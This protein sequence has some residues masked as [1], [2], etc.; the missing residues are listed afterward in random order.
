MDFL[1]KIKSNPYHVLSPLLMSGLLNGLPDEQF[2]K[3]MYRAQMG[4]K[5]DLDDPKTLNEK[6]QWLKL[7]DRNPDYPIMV[8][9]YD[10]KKYVAEKIGEEYIIPTLGVWERFEDIDFEALPDSFVLNCTHDSGGLVVVKDKKKLDL[11]A[12][13]KKIN[14]SL[15]N[16]YYYL[17]REWPYK[18]IKPRIIAE[19]YMEDETGELVDYKF[20][21]FNGKVDCV[22]GCFD[23][24]SGD[25]KFYFFDRG[26][27]LKRYNK[28][29]KEAP[30]G[31]TKPKPRN[32]DRMFD[33]AE[34]L[35][36]IVGAP[37][38]R[39]DLY[40]VYDRIYFGE[41]TLYPSSGFDL[42]RLPETDLMFGQRVDLSPLKQKNKA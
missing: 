23:R 31:F 5:L 29:G 30:E 2:L 15:K 42:G 3:M 12:A 1:K 14:K 37:F 35:G 8:D 13:R 11:E 25:T 27:N 19:Q 18:K 26:W 36:G 40:S 20:Y 41:I 34:K 7:H 9:K 6:I 4:K 16:N 28:R 39:V 32:M 22:L 24:A 38:L 10:A 17:G 33:V 21:C